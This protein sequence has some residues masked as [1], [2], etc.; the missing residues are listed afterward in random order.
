MY[1]QCWNL[2]F[3]LLDHSSPYRNTSKDMSCII[4]M[5]YVKV[6]FSNS[7]H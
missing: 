1:F 4:S 2:R 5:G 7:S 6:M 3:S